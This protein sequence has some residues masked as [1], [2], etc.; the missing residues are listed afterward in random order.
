M[1]HHSTSSVTA[2]PVVALATALLA[3]CSDNPRVDDRLASI[4]PP[5]TA[6]EVPAQEA[7]ANAAEPTIDPAA[8]NSAEI[9][10]VLPEGS[11]CAFRYTSAG[12]PTFAVA[13]RPDGSPIQ[14]VVKVNGH[15]VKLKPSSSNDETS[16]S[17]R[18]SMAAEP[19]RITLQTPGAPPANPRGDLKRE[20]DMVFEVGDQLRVGYRGYLECASQPVA[21]S[22]R[23]P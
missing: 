2:L 12:K 1:F 17:R 3:G 23:E 9:G 16:T 7:L 11:R 10:K 19:I 22:A 5:E 13:T 4:R 8:L 15:L 20:A 6:T 21:K 18:V 14:A